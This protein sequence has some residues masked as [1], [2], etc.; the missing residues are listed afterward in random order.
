MWKFKRTK[1]IPKKKNKA[2]EL[3]VDHC[4]TY[5]KAAAVKAV[6]YWHKDT[7][8]DQWDTIE[9]LETDLYLLS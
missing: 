1:I 6:L 4:K 7:Q 3:I 5:H 2:Q 9:I 8:I